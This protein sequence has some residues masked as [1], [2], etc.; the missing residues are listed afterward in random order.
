MSAGLITLL[1]FL[2]SPFSVP[3]P[4]RQNLA[5]P[6]S[7]QTGAVVVKL[8]APMYPPLA[9]ATNIAGD[10]DVHLSIPQ[11]RKIGSAVAVSGHPL[12]RAAALDSA[13]HAQ[14]EC[15][16]CTEATTSFRLVFTFQTEGD[17]SSSPAASGPKSREPDK[18]YPIIKDADDRVTVTALVF[19]IS[20]P[21]FD[22][23]KRRSL[24]CLD[25]WI[26]G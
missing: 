5:K 11:D 8:F 23:G 20:D 16:K 10:V 1:F 26:C 2:A 12:L 18:T 3:E 9:R 6:S 14:F 24:K 17:C 25:L 19:C 4:Q 7:S 13:Q 21:P 15:R 22:L